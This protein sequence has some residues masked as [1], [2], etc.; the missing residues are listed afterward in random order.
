MIVTLY[1]LVSLSFMMT[2]YSL[3][4]LHRRFV[5]AFAFGCL[6]SSGYGFLS[7]AWPFGIVEVIWAVIAVR[8]FNA[9]KTSYEIGTGTTRPSNSLAFFE[10]GSPDAPPP[11]ASVPIDEA[12]EP[13]GACRLTSSANPSQVGQPVTFVARLAPPP[14]GDP[15]DTVTFGVG[16]VVLATIPVEANGAARLTTSALR[17]GRHIVTAFIDG[18]ITSKRKATTLVQVVTGLSA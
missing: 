13:R 7:G 17:A 5:L 2:M 18:E 8:R 10:T 9:E 15:A 3:E 4:H 6:L 14:S 11:S 1:G 16:L 12:G